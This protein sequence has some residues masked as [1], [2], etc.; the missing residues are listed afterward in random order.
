MTD[1]E[2]QEKRNEIFDSL[3]EQHIKIFQ[4]QGEIHPNWALVASEVAR[5]AKR[6]IP[7]RGPELLASPMLAKERIE[8]E[9]KAFNAEAKA[10]KAPADNEK[11]ELY[12]KALVMGL[13]P[14]K[15]M[16]AETLKKLIEKAE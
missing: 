4:F 9:L 14:R 6:L 7:H 8:A 13:K 11:A 10:P 5:V 3:K 1:L 12:Q 15:N 2:R 16:K